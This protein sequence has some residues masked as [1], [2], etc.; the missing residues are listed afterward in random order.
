MKKIAFL[1]CFLCSVAYGQSLMRS[2]FGASLGLVV[3]I[4]THQR[5]VGIAAKAY[6][7]DYFYQINLG[8]TFTFSGLNYGNRKN[9]F[10]A[11][12]YLGV[13][14]LAGKNTSPIDFE[15]DGLNH[16]TAHNYGVGFNYLYYWDNAQT[17]QLSGGF[18]L[19]IHNVG[20]RFENDVF[21]G[22]ARDRFR[23]GHIAMSYRTSNFKYNAGTYFW[24]GETEG[25]TWH[26]EPT[27]ECPNG[28]KI[29]EDRPYGRTS[30]GILY[31]GVLV[32]VPYGNTVH[33]RMGIDS[34]NVRN[35]LQ[36]KLI[37]DAIILPKKLRHY[38]PHYPRLDENGCI[39]FDATKVRKDRF[40]LQFGTNDSWGN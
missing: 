12:N 17:S 4:G 40:F 31:G 33:W 5:S 38:T 1:F 10:E 13:L 22:Q 37:H 23:T 15:L 30:H 34:E 28:F 29:L 27:D 26:K 8:S 2:K 3:N 11:R 6:Y 24:T 32:N 18:G 35:T 21:G 9:Y 16:Q 19:H 36:N 7:T 39:T 20:I 25:T 14:L